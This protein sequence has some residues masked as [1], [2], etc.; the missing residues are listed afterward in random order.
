MRVSQKKM[1]CEN[2]R[3]WKQNLDLN[4]RLSEQTDKERMVLCLPHSNPT[5]PKHFQI[6]KVKSLGLSSPLYLDLE[7]FQ[8]KK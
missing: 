7:C 8:I 1:R 5:D 3:A 4:L 2:K 6:S